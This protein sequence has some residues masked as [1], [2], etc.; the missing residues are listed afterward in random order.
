M[1]MRANKKMIQQEISEESGNIVLLRD[2]SN[3]A[4]TSKRERTRNDIDASVRMLMGKYGK[5][6][7]FIVSLFI[8]Y[9]PIVTATGASV[10]VYLDESKHFKGLFFQDK[11]MKEAFSA[12][13]EFLCLDAT[14]KLLD[15]GLPVY[16]MLCEDS[17]GQS[18]IVAVCLIVSEDSLS[19]KWMIN[20]FNKENPN[21]KIILIVMAD[22]KIGERD[23]IKQCLPSAS[24]LI[25]LFHTLRSFRRE[26]SCERWG[27]HL[28]KGCY[29]LN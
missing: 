15:L 13:H 25:C 10:V 4:A 9:L 16:L 19:V 14:Y 29:V 3:I 6:V 1:D 18:E 5:L 21:W 26:V 22:K 11:Q 28:A 8:Y 7:L 27:L 20:A 24:L 17:N 2:L 23:V 12:Y